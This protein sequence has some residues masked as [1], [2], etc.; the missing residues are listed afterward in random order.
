MLFAK[1]L[2]SQQFLIF[3]WSKQIIIFNLSSDPISFL[4]IIEMHVLI[5]NFA[6][7]NF[8]KLFNN[9]F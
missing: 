1:S 2:K 7:I 6:A 4:D 8:L 3:C 5:G 9:S